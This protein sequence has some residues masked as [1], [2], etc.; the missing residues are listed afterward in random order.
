MSQSISVLPPK[1]L[2]TQRE[3]AQEAIDIQNACNLS[4]LVHSW[5]KVVMELRRMFPDMSTTFYN[6]H[7]VNQ[8]WASKVHDLTRM[9][10][11]D[12]DA[13]IKAYEACQK[14][15]KTE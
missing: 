2:R 5:A 3:L 13:F 12:T 8:L 15:A 9:G 6:T 1:N 11:S 10:L 7:P 4:G 14:L